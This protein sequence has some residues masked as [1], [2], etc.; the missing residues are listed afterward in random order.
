M[1]PAV[2]QG[3]VGIE[4]RIADEKLLEGLSF[5][6]HDATSIAVRAE[7]G[8]LARLEGGCQVPIGA[9]AEVNGDKVTLTGL[10]ASVDGATMVKKEATADCKD[11]EIMGRNLAEE[12]LGL[13]GKEILEEVYGEEIS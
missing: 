9:F 5:L 10:V 12:I 4:L 1:L 2:G 3:A 6:Q 7:R 8:F 11:A 13:G